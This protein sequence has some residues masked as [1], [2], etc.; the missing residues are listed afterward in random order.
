MYQP[1][2]FKLDSGNSDILEK[3]PDNDDVILSS[4][5]NIPLISLGF[6]HFLHRT[7][8]AMSI[9][10]NIKSK[11]K[12]YYIVNPFEPIIPNYDD[13]L[14]K[15]TNYYLDIKKDTPEISSRVFYKLWEILFTFNIGDQKDLTSTV[16]SKKSNI[17]AQSIIYYRQKLGFGIK[18][19]KIFSV[20]IP[21]EKNKYEQINDQLLSYYN[22]N[23]SGLIHY[24][25]SSNKTNKNELKQLQNI[26]EFKKDVEKT[27]KYSNLIV[28]D[29]SLDWTD[30]NYQ[31]QEGYQLI[32]GEI[33][34]ALKS[35]MK[36][37]NFVL[38]IFETFTIPS[39]KLVYL[40]SSFYDETYIYKPFFSRI[41]DSEKYIVCKGF[42]FDQAKDVIILNKKIKS[43]EKI[44]DG[45]N[46]NKFVYDFL[47]ELSIPLE[48]LDRFRFI[49]I[50]I[51]NPQQIMINEI[52]IYIKK[53]NYYGE[54]YHI[55]REKQIDATKWWVSNFY[56]PSNNLL[57]KNKEDLQKLLVNSQNKFNMEQSKFISAL[58]R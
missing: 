56:P 53:N 29:G 16:F 49:N 23:K 14:D 39:I 38:K 28:A 25:K 5:I 19:D 45:M 11:N 22:S 3:Q 15:L 12:F 55:N 26:N 42:K 44:F 32:L 58:I 41:S 27:K 31:E 9:A 1:F 6:H 17:L 33:I 4:T 54:Q 34:A 36:S 47:P 24:V 21:S 7:K 52:V 46:S 50:K 2:I 30:K 51:A 35:Q 57:E 10:N 40:L 8:N 13:S 48:Y 43:L 18:N 37:G 20:L